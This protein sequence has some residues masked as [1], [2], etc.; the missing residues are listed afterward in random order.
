MTAAAWRYCVTLYC[1]VTCTQ[2]RNTGSQVELRGRAIAAV[3]REIKSHA[4]DAAAAAASYQ[5]RQVLLEWLQTRI[6]SSPW[7]M[8]LSW[9]ERELGGK[10][11]G[12]RLWDVR[13]PMQD[14]KSLRVA[15]V[16]C[17]TL[18]NTH[19]HIQKDREREGER[20][21]EGSGFRSVILLAQPAGLKRAY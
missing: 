21:K 5:S 1:G 2:T 12:G 9:P 10:M 14:F 6:T 7:V 20:G 17:V 3:T 13:I 8:K 18:V 19:T 16:I 4:T 15:F 11:P